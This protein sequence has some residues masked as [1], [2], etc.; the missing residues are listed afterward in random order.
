MKKPLLQKQTEPSVPRPEK[1]PVERLHPDS[2]HGLTAQQVQERIDA[3]QQNFDSTPATRTEKQIILRNICTLFNLVNIIFFVAILAVGS[4]KD[5]LFMAIVAA[6]TAIGIIQE[7]RAKRSIDSLSFLTAAKAKVLRDGESSEI[8][9]DEIV[10]DDIIILSAGDQVPTDCIVASGFC[11]ADESF[12]TG[13]SDAISK[14]G[15][16]MLLAGS[17]IVSGSV[18]ARAERVSADNYISKIS[19]SAKTV[20]KQVNSEIMRTMQAIVAVI[21]IALIPISIILF[22]NQLALADATIHSA[23][24]NTTAALI[25]MVPEGLMLLTSTV[26]A[27]SVVRLT[28]QHVMVQ[29]LY[30]IETLARMYYVWIRPAPLPKAL[31]TAKKLLCWT[32]C[33]KHRFQRLSPPLP[34]HWRIT[35]PLSPLL[36]RSL[37]IPHLGAPKKQPPFPAVP[38]GPAPLSK[39]RALTFSAQRNL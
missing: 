30:C 28:Q 26:L 4:V 20:K 38:S 6:N 13:E 8:P 24:L 17:F 29:E 3:G 36:P 32:S 11:E 15:N 25:A 33:L 18:H 22:R 14:N 1:R 2:A 12:L 16:D 34:P 10:L 9:I 23:V 37:P 39:T 27:A 7:I 31:W 5:T 35:T 21:S 19:T